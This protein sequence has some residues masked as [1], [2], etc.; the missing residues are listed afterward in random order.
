MG[1][2][3]YLVDGAVALAAF[4]VSAAIVVVAGD[5]P[6]V[7]SPDVFAF[8]LVAAHSAG[9]VLRRPRPIAAV[10]LSLATG[11]GYAAA[12]YPPALFPVVLLTVYSAAA[13]LPER[14][15]RLLGVAAFLVAAV[16]STLGPGSTNTSVPLLV[17][18]A[19]VLGN[20][21]R[22]RRL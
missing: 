17:A 10:V 21:V 13:R 18:G 5:D 3:D 22:A 4:A 9:V 20:F 11:V 2:R 7:R 6:E 12:D 15:S 1:R 19:W 14:P 16:T 8:G